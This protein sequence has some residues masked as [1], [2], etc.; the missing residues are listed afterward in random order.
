[1]P[2]L[3]SF[4]VCEKVVIDQQQKPTLISLFQALAA[5]VPEGQSMPKDAIGGTAW[6]V[7]C[8]WFFSDEEATRSYDQVIEVM[9]P[10][11]SPSPIKGR[12]TFKEIAKDQQGTR[13]YINMFGMP[14]A[15]VGILDVNVWIELNNEKVTDTFTY[16]IKIE[17]TKQ[18]P[19][20]TDISVAPA[21]SQ[22][23]P[24]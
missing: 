10:D 20:P 1:M 18:P 9:L 19:T 5:F 7:F 13:A 23:K 4:L 16:R 15:Q 21:L 8:E 3:G 22:T 14:I 11:G 24:S 6:S 17:H 12:L 2:R